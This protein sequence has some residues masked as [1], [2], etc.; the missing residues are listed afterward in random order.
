MNLKYFTGDWFADNAIMTEYLDDVEFY[1]GTERKKILNIPFS[2]GG[3][4]LYGHTW[5]GYLSPTKNRTKSKYEGLYTTKVYDLNPH[6]DEIFSEF[7]K[8]Y[9]PDFQYLQVQMN[10][11]Y[12]IPRHIDSRNV[13]TSILC[14]FGDYEGGET[15][16]EKDDEEIVLNPQLNPECFNGSK[17]YHYVKPFTGK[18]YSL[19]FFN[20]IKRKL[21][22]RNNNNI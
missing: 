10:K 12:T 19:V 4:M 2:V 13:G 15:V 16:Y 22:L 9:F 14:C 6:L 18:R 7:A 21:I 20:N 8:I 5:R 1:S 17:Y 3:S 11:N